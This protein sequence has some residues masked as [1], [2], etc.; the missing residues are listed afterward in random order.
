MLRSQ[1][2]GGVGFR[3]DRGKDVD[4]GQKKRQTEGRGD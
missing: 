4:E 1:E 2:S 3:G